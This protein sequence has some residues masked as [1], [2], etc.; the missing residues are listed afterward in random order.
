MS[1]TDKIPVSRPAIGKLDVQKIAQTVKST[2]IASGPN[3]TEFESKIAQYCGKKYAVAVT[4]GTSALLL[5]LKALNL[6]PKSKVL[7]PTFTIVS[8]LYAIL[9][10]NCIPVFIDVNDRT[11]N[12]DDFLLKAYIKKDIKAAIIVQTY[13][14]GPPMEKISALLKKH[15]IPMLEDTAE[16]FG[17]AQ[18]GKKFGSFGKLSILSFY[19]NKLITTGEG[20]M[21]LTD[22]KEMYERLCNLR[23]L[24]FDKGRKFIHKELSGNYRMTNY[25]AALG[26]SQLKQISSFYNHR[27]LLYRRYV[28]LLGD[29][30]EYIQFQYIPNEINSSYWVFP[31]LLRKKVK[32]DASEFI[33]AL[34][35]NGVEARHFFYPLDRQ[36]FLSTDYRINA[37][38][39][40]NLWRNGLYLPLG[41]GIT[42]KE[43]E[44]VSQVVRMLL[45]GEKV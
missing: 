33:D 34:D 9:S 37:K 15:N 32:Y 30:Q 21:V 31:I 13:A 23:N 18:N 39:S 2:Y 43:V 4:S 44:R 12:V 6:P 16:G 27:Q 14:S 8:A 45:K 1:P 38:I 3:I 11:W 19:A 26:L 41:N 17:G 7:V 36:P 5:A 20:G 25:Q 29:L 22:E 42:K 40:Y 28:E 35:S 24:F 10:C